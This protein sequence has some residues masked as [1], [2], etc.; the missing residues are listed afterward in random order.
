MILRKQINRVLS[1]DKSLINFVKTLPNDTFI[2]SNQAFLLRI[3]TGRHVRTSFF[4]EVW[5][6]D[7]KLRNSFENVIMMANKQPICFV[8]LPSN[9][10][11]K[12]V[13]DSTW[14]EKIIDILPP[15]FTIN[16]NQNLLL[17]R[18]DY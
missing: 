15:G 11:L 1:C 6:N 9:M 8:I 12:S 10:L 3:E 17:E 14:Q 7:S 16:E 13:K 18:K 4:E 2:V 5:D